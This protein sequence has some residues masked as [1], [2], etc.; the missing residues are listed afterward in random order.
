MN[1]AVFVARSSFHTDFLRPGLDY[2]L[3]VHKH[4]FSL[5]QQ[6]FETPAYRPTNVL[7]MSCLK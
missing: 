4:I 3:L 5:F 7:A 1:L 2:K 6:K